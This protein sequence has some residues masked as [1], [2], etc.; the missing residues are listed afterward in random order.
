MIWEPDELAKP[1]HDQGAMRISSEGRPS[2]VFLI[3]AEHIKTLGQENAAE[4]P[5]GWRLIKRPQSASPFSVIRGG[6]G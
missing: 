4:L 6:R 1:S 2:F 3:N 5:L